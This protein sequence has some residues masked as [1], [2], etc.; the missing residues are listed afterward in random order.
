MEAHRYARLNKQGRHDIKSKY[1]VFLTNA[2]R[3]TTQYPAYHQTAPLPLPHHTEN[4][5]NARIIDIIVSVLHICYPYAA[6]QRISPFP[7][8]HSRL[9]YQLPNK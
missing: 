6:M 1:V 7:W 3:S 5:Q 4:R 2:S 9:S 8:Q